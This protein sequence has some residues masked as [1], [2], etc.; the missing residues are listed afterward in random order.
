[1]E[2]TWYAA[3]L[4]RREGEERP[5]Q[6][7]ALIMATCSTSKCMVLT[8]RMVVRA[9]RTTWVCRANQLAATS[10]QIDRKLARYGRN[11]A[12]MMS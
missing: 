5:V 9:R 10:L 8:R 11:P 4:P 3:L 6:L 12:E 1:M 7:L 2:L